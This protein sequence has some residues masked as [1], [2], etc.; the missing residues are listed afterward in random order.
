VTAQHWGKPGQSCEGKIQ[1]SSEQVAG[2]AATA[3]E[4]RFGEKMIAYEC[5]YCGHWHL[6]HEK[7]EVP[8][9]SS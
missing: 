4:W 3:L 6:G 8:R 2:N 5:G 1:Y 9:A 7:V